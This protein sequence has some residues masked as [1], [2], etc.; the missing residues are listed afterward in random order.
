M[1]RPAKKPYTDLPSPVLDQTRQIIQVDIAIRFPVGPHT[2]GNKRTIAMSPERS[3]QCKILQVNYAILIQIGPMYLVQYRLNPSPIREESNRLKLIGIRHKRSRLPGKPRLVGNQILGVVFMS[4]FI[5]GLHA[6]GQ[7]GQFPAG[8][9][10]KKPSSPGI[11]L[12]GD[13]FVGSGPR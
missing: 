9:F 3:K 5:M 7:A 13:A 2:I 6:L 4:L 12:S 1:R 11:I 10:G 8:T